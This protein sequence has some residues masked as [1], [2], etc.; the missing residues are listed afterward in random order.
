VKGLDVVSG[1][2]DL[3]VKIEPDRYKGVRLGLDARRME[4]E[5]A[6]IVSTRGPPPSG[7]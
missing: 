4:A 7:G 5:A 2:V 1:A 6:Q 3:L